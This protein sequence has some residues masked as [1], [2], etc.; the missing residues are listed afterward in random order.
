MRITEM[1]GKVF[2]SPKGDEYGVIRALQGSRPTI[3]DGEV[4]ADDGSGNF[5]VLL[6][7]GAVAFWD[8]ETS[9][10]TVLAESLA[11]FFSALLTPEPVILREG[12]VKSV[13]I[14]PEFAKE[15]GLRDGS[16]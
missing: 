11:S 5:F 8:H 12:Q 10:S 4:F 3:L 1:E 7:S 16:K 13:W 15:F 14:D 6:P 2:R 9:E